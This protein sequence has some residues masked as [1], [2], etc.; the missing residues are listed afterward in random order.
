MEPFTLALPNG[1]VLTGL[2]NLP[3]RS[4]GAPRYLPLVVLL[5]GGTYDAHY[6]DVDTKHGASLTSNAL[7]VPCVAPN[8]PGYRDS[9]SF[10]P[11]PTESNYA[12]EYGISLHGH[13][14]PTLWTQFGQP[15]GCSSMVLH[16]HSIATTGAV[17][18]AGLH[19]RDSKPGYPLAGVTFSGFGS[20]TA[21][22][23]DDP[24]GDSPDP[25]VL[26]IPHQEKD[27]RLLTPGLADPSV[28]QHSE[29][30][31]HAT[32]FEEFKSIDDVWLP[33]WREWAAEVEVPVMWAI[34][35]RDAVWRATEEHIR[36]LTNAF[37]RSERVDGSIVKGAPHNMELSY[38]SRG[39]YA[40]CFGFAL[41]C[42]AALELKNAV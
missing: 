24:S 8:R 31:N 7:G 6:F 22:M 23:P 20:Q 39:W 30:L 14:L 33:K 38:W 28:Y 25:P 12:R 29:R 18:A 9:T 4:P 26:W 1:A 17:V 16:C 40:R 32:R 11:I 36:E 35:G 42:A 19:A 5:H 21:W 15:H 37:S 2:C 27:Q 41:E 10:Y 13:I 34:A 3:P